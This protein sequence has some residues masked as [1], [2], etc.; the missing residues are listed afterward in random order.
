MLHRAF[1][2]FLFSQNGSLLMQQRAASKITFPLI[3]ANTCCSHPLSGEGG[4]SEEAGAAGVIRAARRK[5]QQELGI[6]PTQVPS[7]SFTWITRVHYAGSCSAAGT[8]A[9]LWGEHEIDWILLCQPSAPVRVEP[10]LNEVNAVREFTQAELRKWIRE[11]GGSA[12]VSPWFRVMEA[13]GLLYSWW[14]ALLEKR[15]GDVLQRGTIH[16]QHELETI[17]AGAGAVPVLPCKALEASARA[18][19]ARVTLSTNKGT[20]SSSSCDDHASFA[21]DLGSSEQSVC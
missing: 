10:N 1:S 13:S 3:W 7:D 19:H 8:P 6:N 12:A 2:V 15:V 16:R 20:T 21:L 11:E 9:P 5:L 14:D 17:I 4:E 18:T